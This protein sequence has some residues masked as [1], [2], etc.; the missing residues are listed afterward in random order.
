MTAI[1]LLRMGGPFIQKIMNLMLSFQGG[2]LKTKTKAVALLSGFQL[3]VDQST[4]AMKDA[5]GWRVLNKFL[6]KRL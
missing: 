5:A 6:R 4:I 3:K 1:Y 2:I